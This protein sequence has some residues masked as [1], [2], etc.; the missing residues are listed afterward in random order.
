LKLIAH[1]KTDKGLVRAENEDEFC[2]EKDLGF[3]AVADGMGGHASGEVA[4]K[5]A[6][7]IVRNCFKNEKEPLSS[8][9]TSGIR[10]ANK[11]IYDASKSQSQWNGMGTT[12]AAVLLTGNRLSIAHVG[13]SRVYLVRGGNLEQITDDHTIVSEQVQKGLMTREEADQS[14]MRHILTRALGIDPDVNVDV[15]EL[16]MSKGD[17]LVLCSDGL[18]ELVSDDE[19]LYAAM[20]SDTPEIACDQLVDMAN[21]KGGHD[22][23]TVIVAF[24]CREGLLSRFLRML[25]FIRR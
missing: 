14:G 3:L 5:M 6:I 11:A 17:R 7:D 23:I 19:I 24:L 8:R 1:G 13:D 25:G 20:S 16:T 21:Q 10:L 9:M 22:N 4:S 2:I 12:I 15:D 18:S